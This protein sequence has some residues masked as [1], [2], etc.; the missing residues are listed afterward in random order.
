V[1]SS[2]GTLHDQL[3]AGARCIRNRPRLVQRSP[4]LHRHTSGKDDFQLRVCHSSAAPA[5]PRTLNVISQGYGRLFA[6]GIDEVCS[7]LEEW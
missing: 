2:E 6:Y 7:W 4:F 3:D 1:S 5:K